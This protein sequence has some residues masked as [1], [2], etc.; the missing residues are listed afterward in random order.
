[1]PKNPVT[2]PITD[3]ELA[4]AHL[5]LSGTMNDR[6][7][8]E[9]VGLSPDS[10]S[11]TKAKPR[12]RDY[13]IQHRAA[14]MERLADQEAAGLRK[15]NIG[16]DQVL[17][18]LWELANL[19]SEATKGSI[20]GQVKA[21]SLIIAIEGLIPR[22][23]HAR[24]AALQ[25]QFAS[26]PVEPETAVSES[27]RQQHQPAAPEESADAVADTQAQNADPPAS[28]LGPRPEPARNLAEEA[29]LALLEH[30][31]G[32]LNPFVNPEKPT[33]IPPASASIFDSH[34]DASP[35]L[36]QPFSPSLNIPAW[37]RRR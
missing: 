27:P 33:R 21:L 28:E 18:R 29:M 15:L 25:K 13:M 3:Q 14:V 9:A 12:V 16:R 19:S 37:C 36:R 7:A 8:A 24:L 17:D 1:M 5:I 34:L 4:F 20:A 30:K 10:A 35:L 22:P 6:R 23:D 32:P 31:P 26:S 11:Y 2:D